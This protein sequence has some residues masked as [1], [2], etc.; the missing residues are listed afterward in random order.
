MGTFGGMYTAVSGMQIAQLNLS[1]TGHNLANASTRGYSRQNVIQSDYYYINGVGLGTN[2]AELRQ[3]RNKFLDI[4]YREEVSKGSYYEPIVYSGQEIESLLGELNNDGATQSVMQDLWD[5][6]NNVVLDPTNI[7]VRGTFVNNCISYLDKMQ[8]IYKGL[9]D[10]Q[11]NLNTEIKSTVDKINYYTEEVN[12]YNQ[13]I[14][15]AELNGDNANDYR[16]ARNLALDNLSQLGDITIKEKSDGTYDLSIGNNILLS[17]GQVKTIGLKYCNPKSGLVEPVFT[18]SKDILPYDADVDLVYD[19][20]REIST[21][22]GEDKSYLKGLLISRG[23]AP[24]T[25]MTEENLVANEPDPTDLA[26]YPLG[27]LDPKYKEDRGKWERD[28][29]NVQHATIPKFMA[30]IDTLFNKIVTLINDTLAPQDHDPTTAPVGID[31][32][33][34]QFLEIFTRKYIDR[35][36]GTGTYNPEDGSDY[37]SLYTIGNVEIN[38]ELLDAGG[39][40][41]IAFSASGDESDTSIVADILDK[42]KS[43]IVN[44]PMTNE[45]LDIPDYY[46]GMGIEEA[47]NFLVTTTATSTNEAN[48]FLEAQ[49]VLITQLDAQKSAISGVSGD[50]EMTNMMQFEYAYSASAQVL[51]ALDEML[52]T[53]IQM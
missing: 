18:N 26:T 13:L 53:L 7:E 28:M 39:Y 50:E 51:N 1:V 42:W 22:K 9:A 32:D 25:Y 21:E 43:P 20:R 12:K 45:T 52:L 33:K 29:F 46:D 24:V 16:D 5:S 48:S 27:E 10:Y 38:E 2:V 36:D 34:T 31:E 14:R 6:I 11:E 35:Y 44:L 40:D 41:K 23:S 8:I 47:Y 19:L 17:N 37:Y 3:I 15:K 30:N 4:S 49:D